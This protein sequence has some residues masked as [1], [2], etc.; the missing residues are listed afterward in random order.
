MTQMFIGP[1]ITDAIAAFDGFQQ[2]MNTR[3]ARLLA[4]RPPGHRKITAHDGPVFQ[5][6]VSTSAHELHIVSTQSVP[7]N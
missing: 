6:A 3:Y 4:A 1:S 7:E 2:N 5:R